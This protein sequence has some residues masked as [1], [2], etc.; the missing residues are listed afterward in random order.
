MNITVREHLSCFACLWI[1]VWSVAHEVHAKIETFALFMA[2]LFCLRM[3]LTYAERWI[4]KNER[5]ELNE[6]NQTQ[7]N[8]L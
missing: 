5:N 1:A 7:S 6:S 8:K 4:I 3:L 2:I